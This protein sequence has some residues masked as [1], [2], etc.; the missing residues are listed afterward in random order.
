MRPLLFL[1]TAYSP[2]FSSSEHRLAASPSIGESRFGLG[3]VRYRTFA[4]V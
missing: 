4:V 3:L 1:A 2:R